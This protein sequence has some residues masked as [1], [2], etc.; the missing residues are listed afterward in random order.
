MV[1]F[2]EDEPVE[3]AAAARRHP[4]RHPGHLDHAGAA[5]LGLQEQGRAV[6]AGRRHRL[7]AGADRRAAG[8]RHRSQD[9]ARRS[10]APPRLDQPFAALAFKVMTD[11]FVG[12]LTYFRVYS[13]KLNS[14]SY[15]LNA[16]T[17][18]KERV[19]RILEMH[20][21][22]REDVEQI[23]AGA[24]AAAVGLKQTTTGDTLCDRGRAGRAG[25]DR[26]PRPRHRR[27]RRAEDQGRPG[28][29]DQAPSSGW[30]R[31][32]RPSASAPTRRPARPS[33]PAWASCT[34][35][36]SSTG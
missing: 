19:G 29:A 2:L 15:V 30:P 12:K 31:R 5:R 8:G 13:G 3:E 34:W 21:N 32:T 33:S 6:A 9:A 17:G 7:P 1:A 25:V 24:I 35:R 18:R 23:G 10:S 27:G 4:R 36:S 11:P 22:H 26:L 20:A 14:G 28:Q 16:S